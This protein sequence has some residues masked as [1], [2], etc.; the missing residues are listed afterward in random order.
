MTKKQSVAIKSFHDGTCDHAYELLGL[1]RCQTGVAFR[2]WAPSARQVFVVGDFNGWEQTDPMFRI[3]ENGLWEAEL[4]KERI[5]LGQKYK[6]KILSDAGVFYKSDPYG[7][8]VECATSAATV[9]ED[10]ECYQWRDE[11]WL[12]YRESNKG[13]WYKKPL[14]IYRFHPEAWTKHEDGS[15]FTYRE[16]ASELSSYAKQMGYTHVEMMTKDGAPYFAPLPCFGTPTDFMGFVDSMHEAGIGVIVEW[17]PSYFGEDEHGLSRFDGAALYEYADESRMRF[18]L[19]GAR[20]FDLGRCE[21]VSFL[22]SCAMLWIERYHVDGLCARGVSPAIY[23][24]YDKQPGEW[25]PNGYG[26]NRCVEAIRF[27]RQL[28]RTV[29]ESHPDVLMIADE[30]TSWQGV[31]DFSGYSGLGFDLKWNT[32]WERDAV[33]YCEM[34]PIYRKYHHEN[35][36]FPMTYAHAERYLLPITTIGVQRKMFGDYWQK[37]ATHRALLGFM[38]T[39]P[40]K[41]LSLMGNEIGQFDSWEQEGQ[42][43]WSFLDYVSHARFQSYVAELNHLYLQTPALWCQDASWEGFRWI[44]TDNREQSVL[45]YYRTDGK[46]SDV[47]VIL[48]FTPVVRRDYLVGVPNGGSYE[49]I[50]N[51]DEIRFGGSGI[52]N[53]R[54]IF[55]SRKSWNYLPHS[56]RLTLPPLGMIILR[57]K[58]KTKDQ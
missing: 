15:L 47:V 49:E 16:L 19:E 14:H 21:V 26:D 6:Y 27:F 35:L 48:N 44:D 2:V 43:A 9:V 41:K 34:D 50:L 40:G 55:A 17:C 23:L 11:G 38:M 57:C 22:V 31:T 1:H 56:I 33:A 32:G 4:P 10:V 52:T 58:K 24:D 8:C 29:K 37:F 42:V 45:S 54:E 13:N 7:A 5:A 28:N 46:G 18:G 20:R 30:S 53:P 25:T 3:S 12:A 51:S 36:T 39:H